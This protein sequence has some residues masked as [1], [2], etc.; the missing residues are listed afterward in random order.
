MLCIA[1]TFCGEE[2]PYMTR[3]QARQIT[4]KQFKQL[5]PR[6]GNYRYFFKTECRDFA[7]GVIQEEVTEDSAPLP[8]W[9]GKVHGQVMSRE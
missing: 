6:K 1:Y 4:L 9:D 2:V 5:M 3:V 7:S 8:L